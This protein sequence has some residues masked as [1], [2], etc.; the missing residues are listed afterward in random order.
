[1]KEKVPEI[2]I[3][4]TQVM[5]L[6]LAFLPFPRHYVFWSLTV[7]LMCFWSLNAYQI[8]PTIAT[9]NTTPKF[10]SFNSLL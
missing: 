9:K 3:P 10:Y 4:F 1:M 8:A 5:W 7:L 6:L 2:K